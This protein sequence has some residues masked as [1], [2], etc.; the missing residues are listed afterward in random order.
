MLKNVKKVYSKF[1]IKT[2]KEKKT[3]KNCS[4]K[5]EIEVKVLKKTNFWQM[6]KSELMSAS[7]CSRTLMISVAFLLRL[8]FLASNSASV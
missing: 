3:Q 1:K 8:H 4:K 2:K 6:A 5:F 7:E